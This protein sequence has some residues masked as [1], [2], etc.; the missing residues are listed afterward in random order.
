MIY[1]PSDW[2]WQVTGVGIYGSARQG[3]V[4][5]PTTDAAYLAFTALNGPGP[6]MATTAALDA[7]LIAAGLPP[8]G[9]TTPA[10]ISLQAALTTATSAACAAIT[11]QVYTDP[12]HQA[13]GQNAAMIVTMSGGA[14]TSASPFFAAFNTYA[15]AFGLAPAAFATLITTLTNQSLALSSALNAL[16]AATAAA[17]TA[18]QLATALATFETAIASVVT[19]INAAGM[20]FPLTAPAA[21]VI[22]GI[23]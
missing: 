21:I 22:P 10:F 5:N 3:L 6:I 9:L 12:A 13:A 7:V 8:S 4:T 11:S 14:P 20:P 17:T 2:Y 16:Q 15:A 18:A 19:T 23:N 1:N